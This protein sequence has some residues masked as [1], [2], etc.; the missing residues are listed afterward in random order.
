MGNNDTKIIQLDDE[1]D[2]HEKEKGK[3]TLITQSPVSKEQI[4]KIF[5][6]TPAQH[7]HKRPGKG[8]ENRIASPASTSRRF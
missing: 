4:L 6:K 2:V 5:R 8:E 1:I 7:V 3:Y